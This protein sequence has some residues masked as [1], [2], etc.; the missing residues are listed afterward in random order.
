M[1]TRFCIDRMLDL[2]GLVNRRSSMIVVVRRYPTIPLEMFSGILYGL[3]TDS[4]MY[5][6]TWKT[7][8]R[9]RWDPDRP[10][11][12]VVKCCH[13]WFV[14]RRVYVV[15][16]KSIPLH[17]LLLI[18]ISTTLSDMSDSLFASSAHRN[19]CFI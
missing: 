3:P 10:Y 13:T 8:T 1:G 12:I 19:A 4:P 2:W 5:C 6:I 14:C 11:D 17:G 9:E 7:C 16:V 15:L 18:W